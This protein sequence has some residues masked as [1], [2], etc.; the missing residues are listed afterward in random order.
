MHII[1]VPGFWVDGSSWSEVTPVEF[2]EDA[3]LVDLNEE[4]RAA[5]RARAVVPATVIS[6]EFP[7][8][9][10]RE[11]IAAGQPFAAELA[12][13]RDAEYVDLPTGR[14]PQ[15]TKPRELSEAIIAAVDRAA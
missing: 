5:F 10:L 4:L 8:A 3:D 11:W 13:I 15:F 9:L 2:F 7:S 14:W 6:C 12:R 1:L